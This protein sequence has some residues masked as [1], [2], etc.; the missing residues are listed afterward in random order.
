MT[1]GPK[2]FYTERKYTKLGEAGFEGILDSP[3]LLHFYGSNLQSPSRPGIVWELFLKVKMGKYH[4]D[5][6]DLA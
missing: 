3:F 4:L 2:K 6:L 5:S 1:K